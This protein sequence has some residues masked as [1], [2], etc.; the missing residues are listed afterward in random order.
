MIEVRN[1]KHYE[2]LGIYIGRTMRQLKG[3]PLGNPFKVKP[4]GIY[5]RDESVKLYRRW[6]WKHV[7]SRTG[8]VYDEIRRLKN[9]AE[10]SDLTLLCWCK[11]PD[12]EVACH[13][14]VVKACIEWLMKN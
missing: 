1:R 11:Q 5:D 10:N 7:E 8:V 9:L 6:L 12:R 3:S 13:G 14:D 4:H 2:G